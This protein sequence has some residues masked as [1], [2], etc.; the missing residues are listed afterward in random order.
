MSPIM[1]QAKS[2]AVCWTLVLTVIMNRGLSQTLMLQVTANLALQKRR[3]QLSCSAYGCEQS[4]QQF[5][6]SALREQRW[7]GCEDC[8]KL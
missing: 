5:G 8:S 1:S 2:A 3:W 4:P 7:R 6:N